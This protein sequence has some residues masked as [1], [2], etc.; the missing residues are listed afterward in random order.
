MIFNSLDFHLHSQYGEEPV[1][2]SRPFRLRI[3]YIVDSFSMRIP[4]KIK[5]ATFHKL[6]VCVCYK[7]GQRTPFYA[8]EG[9]GMVEIIEPKIASIYEALPAEAEE[10]VKGYLSKGLRIAAKSDALFAEP[11]DLWDELLSTVGEAFDFDLRMSRS[12]RSRRWACE[13]VMRITPTAYHYDVLVKD[14]KSRQTIQRHRTKTT[15]PAFPFYRGVGFSKVRWDD[16]D[17]VG[18]SK[19]DKEVFRFHAELPA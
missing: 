13:A 5:T 7:R 10:R 3:N 12:H 16:A 4:K 14:S 9:I 1:A 19:D 11:L 2:L 8:M 17:I 18:L 6:N 15:E